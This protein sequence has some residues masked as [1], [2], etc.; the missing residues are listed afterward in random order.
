MRGIV[1]HRGAASPPPGAVRRWLL[2][3]VVDLPDAVALVAPPA[4]FR[5]H[6]ARFAQACGLSA[7]AR[8][9]ARAAA[10]STGRLAALEAFD[11]PRIA[12]DLPPAALVVHDEEDADVPLG[13]RRRRR[14]GLGGSPSPPTTQGARASPHPAGS[15]GRRPCHR[16]PHGATRAG[17]EPDQGA[18]CGGHALLTTW[19]R[20]RPQTPP[21]VPCMTGPPT[22]RTALGS[23]ACIRG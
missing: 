8:S 23:V 7:S 11:L 12:R 14:R 5:G 21:P 19:L 4:D 18:R 9:P 17:G 20:R 3:G 1:G 2:D 13:G 15:G 22:A 6:L 10:R 16:L